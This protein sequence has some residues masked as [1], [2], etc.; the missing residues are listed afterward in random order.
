MSGLIN[1]V[2]FYYGILVGYEREGVIDLVGIWADF[3][4]I[5][6]SE[7]KVRVLRLFSNDFIYIIFLSDIVMGMEN[8]LV[9]VKG[10]GRLWGGR[11][12]DYEG[13]RFWWWRKC[14]DFGRVGGYLNFLCDEMI[15][16]Y[17]D[18]VLEFIF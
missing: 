7:E 12:C 10:L 4:G 17:L 9:R 16:L 11:Y 8:R 14:F 13:E 1:G 6:F 18:Y 5:V 2:R 15:E 3:K